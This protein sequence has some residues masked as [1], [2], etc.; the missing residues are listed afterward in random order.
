MIERRCVYI[1]RV[2]R[3]RIIGWCWDPRN[4]GQSLPVEAVGSN[5]SSVVAI[6]CRFRQDVRDAISGADFY[7]FRIVLDRLVDGKIRGWG[8]IAK[9]LMRPVV[10][11]AVGPA[12]PRAG[13]SALE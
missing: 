3:R 2:N 6:A 9:G 8:E 4:P 5:D 12:V 1:D 7:G 13:S 11:E 10:I